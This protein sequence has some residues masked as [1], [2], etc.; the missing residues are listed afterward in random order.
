MVSTMTEEDR[1]IWRNGPCRYEDY[2]HE[3]EANATLKSEYAYFMQE[4]GVAKTVRDSIECML[5]IPG[6]GDRT[7]RVY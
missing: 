6:V 1:L 4:G 5:A 2:Q 3:V 7:E